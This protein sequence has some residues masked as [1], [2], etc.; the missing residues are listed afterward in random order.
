MKPEISLPCSLEPIIELQLHYCRVE[1]QVPLYW[2]YKTEQCNDRNK[3]K[4]NEMQ[5]IKGEP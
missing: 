1:E 4:K 5:K 3:G 2:Y